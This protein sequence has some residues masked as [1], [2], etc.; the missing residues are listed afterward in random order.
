MMNTPISQSEMYAVL[1]GDIVG[2]SALS[3]EEHRQVVRTVKAVS[4]VFPDAVIGSVDF[5]SG[6]S[7]QLLVSDCSRSL[8][9]A[10]YVRA[11]LKREKRLAVDS[12]ISIAW[13][14]WIWR[15]W[16]WRGCRNPPAIFLQRP[17]VLCRNSE[18]TR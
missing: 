13:G 15:R 14:K 12:R 4:E 11:G 1:T 9:V 5:F 2:S 8:A 10:L 16:I 18:K 3:P 17:A 6:D 7:W